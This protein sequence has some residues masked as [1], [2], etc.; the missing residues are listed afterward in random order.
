MAGLAELQPYPDVEPA[1]TILAEEHVPAITL[2]NGGAA[3]VAKLLENAQLSRFF[4]KTLSVEE[5]GHWKPRPE[6][7]STFVSR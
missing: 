7:T 5:I 2:T 4:S 6:P 1:L 3:I